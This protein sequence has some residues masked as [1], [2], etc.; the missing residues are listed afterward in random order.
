MATSVNSTNTVPRVARSAEAP[1]CI[2]ASKGLHV[3]PKTIYCRFT[4]TS[5]KVWPAKTAYSVRAGCHPKPPNTFDAFAVVVPGLGRDVEDAWRTEGQNGH[6]LR[7]GSCD[8]FVEYC[9]SI[10]QTG[11]DQKYTFTDVAAWLQIKSQ[12]KRISNRSAAPFP[13]DSF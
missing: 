9:L 2:A 10:L 6:E 4:G 1:Q 7:C 3:Q 8:S 5:R 11:T 12:A 13:R